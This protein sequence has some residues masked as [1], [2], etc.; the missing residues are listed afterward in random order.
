MSVSGCEHD[1][2]VRMRAP[3]RCQDVSTMVVSGQLSTMSVS[4]CEHHGGVRTV[5]HH[6]VGIFAPDGA[7]PCRGSR[8][9][10]R[11]PSV[12]PPPPATSLAAG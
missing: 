8:A 4:G 12:A 5:E 3:C 9:S 7:S 6:V 11:R 1:G 2:G 10:L